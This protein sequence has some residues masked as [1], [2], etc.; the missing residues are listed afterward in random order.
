MSK[1]STLISQLPI[2]RTNNTSENDNSEL[3]NNILNNMNQQPQQQ[4]LQQQN[5]QQQFQ[6]PQQQQQQ[7]QQQHQQPPE[8][9]EQYM[10]PN[11][12]N[13]DMYEDIEEFDDNLS[14]KDIILNEVKLPFYVLILSILFQ[15]NTSNNLLKKYIP[16][17]LNS[18]NNISIYGIITK[19]LI[20]T[21]F[22]YI[23]KKTI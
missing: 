23:L 18:E 13:N 16:K 7:H 3:V 21:I 19:A 12:Y 1:S 22:F 4:Q 10:P 6:Q 5:N 20:I 14:S 15:L 17:F 9:Q 11:L 2:D 8:F